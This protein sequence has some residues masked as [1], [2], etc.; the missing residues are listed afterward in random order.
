M[1]S[2]QCGDASVQHACTLQPSDVNV[3]VIYVCCY[4]MFWHMH[5]GWNWLVYIP[6]VTWDYGC[7]WS[8]RLECMDERHD[9][10]NLNVNII[11]HHLNIII[12]LV[13]TP[14][15]LLGPCCAL[16]WTRL[17]HCTYWSTS[18]TVGQKQNQHEDC[19]SV[20]QVMFYDVIQ[21]MYC[22]VIQV[23]YVKRCHD[24]IMTCTCPVFI[25][26]VL[27]FLLFMWPT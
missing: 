11:C 26:T 5:K 16:Y 6:E 17:L 4:S 25:F 13:A 14:S 7:I 22:D 27:S 20:I 10:C 8:T 15:G 18:A 3:N 19:H 21:V 1:T 23:M 12:Q 2:W 24:V 9:C